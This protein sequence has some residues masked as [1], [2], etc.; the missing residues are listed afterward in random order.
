M[1]VLMI[2]SFTLSVMFSCYMTQYHCNHIGEWKEATCQR[3]M[4]SFTQIQSV[5]I[6]LLIKTIFN[7]HNVSGLLQVVISEIGACTFG[8]YL[9]ERI[10]RHETYAVFLF[11]HK[12]L[13]TLTSCLL[14]VISAFLLGAL[15]TFL[16]KQVIFRIKYIRKK[17]RLI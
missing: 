9:F 17:D 2:L 1:I 11:F 12:Y 8:V 4:A 3:F 7:R 13:H 5:S 14:W 16:F 10:W 6:F 15:C